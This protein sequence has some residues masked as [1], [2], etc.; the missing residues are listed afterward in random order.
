MA[1]NPLFRKAALDK[2]ASPE[3]LDVLMQVTSPKGW[4][5]IWAIG[6]V[7]IGVIVWSVIGSIPTRVDGQGI[8]IRGGG[9]REIRAAGEGTLVSLRMAINDNVEANQVVGEIAGRDVDE[10]VRVA[11]AKYAEAAREYETAKAEDEATNAG[12]RATIAGQQADMRRIEG[13]LERAREDLVSRREA[14]EKGLVTRARVQAIERD[15]LSLEANLTASRATI[16][17][18]QASIRAV[19]QRIRA[20]AAAVESTKLDLERLTSTATAVS[21]VTATVAGRVVELKKSIGDRVVN[22]EVLAL[23]EPPS[24][25]LEPIVFVASATG[26]RIKPGMEAQISPSTVKREEY[27]FMKGTVSFVGE[28]PVTPDAA[29]AVVANTALVQELLAGGAKIELRAA[30]NTDGETPSGYQ[31]SSSSGPPYKVDSG[32]AVVVSVIVDRRAPISYVLPILKGTLGA[33]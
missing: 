20:R 30:L 33:T 8:L 5:S 11:Q 15:V 24:S 25:V 29:M 14:L 32:T 9:L 1:E 6:G 13:E 19:E 23:V 28:Y 21:R 27:G 12:T 10:A 7:L 2:L 26:K 31:W 17:N 3:R 18:L 4:L 16:T 22:G